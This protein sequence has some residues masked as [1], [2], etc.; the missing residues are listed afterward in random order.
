MRRETIRARAGAWLLAACA[1]GAA[2]GCETQPAAKQATTAPSEPDAS[3]AAKAKDDKQTEVQRV[4]AENAAII[5]S[6]SRG[7]GSGPASFVGASEVQGPPGS[8]EA[9]AGQPANPHPPEGGPALGQIAAS[10]ELKPDKVPPAAIPETLEQKKQRLAGELALVL[11]DEAARA[12]EPFESYAA[13]AALEMVVPGML[14][15]P[16]S[17]TTLSPR[18]A[19]LLTVWRDMHLA[20]GDDA[21]GELGQ[22]AK[23]TGVVEAAAERMSAWRPLRI[24]RALLCERV[25]G[26]GAYTP[27]AGPKILSG[28]AR[29][30]IVY[31]EID[32]F[33]TRPRTSDE[34]V[35]GFAVE[36]SQELTLYHDAD[37]LLAWRKP[38]EDVSDFSRNRRRD[39]YMV[40][41]IE[42]PANLTV[43]SYRLKVTIRDK[44]T[45]AVAESIMPVEVVADAKLVEAQ[46][47]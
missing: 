5:P 1:V 6:L 38:P 3:A 20:A 30:A 4:L 21:G 14:P 40:Q 24:G 46:G 22:A 15:P 44:A 12:V 31:V 39:F 33:A 45:S 17:I 19:D 34:G 36:L 27:F 37:G 43:G 8:P 10:P 9:L 29:R 32:H 42:L 23:L 47:G 26:F 28:R 13:V 11:K 25:E 41:M 7:G 18:E 2:I 16:A 35:E